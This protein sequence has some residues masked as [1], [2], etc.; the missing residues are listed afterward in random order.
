MLHSTV[1]PRASGLMAKGRPWLWAPVLVVGVVL[2]LLLLL[3]LED[4]QDVIYVPSVIL[5]GAAVVPIAFV[6]FISGRR[7]AFGVGGAA[8]AL[9]ALFGGV[10]GVLGAGTLEYETERS[11]GAL[12]LLSVGL[13]EEA[14]KL[15]IPA[16]V[17]LLLRDRRH[18]ADGLLLGVAAGAGFAVLET[19][20][21][22]FAVLVES[23]GDLTD[24]NSLLVDRGLLSPAAHMAW[25]GL[26]AAALWRAAGRRWRRWAP[27]RF[28]GV[29]LVVSSLHALWDGTSGGW[30]HAGLA[31]ISLGGLLWV[32]HR[33]AASGDRQSPPIAPA[34]PAAGRLAPGA[35]MPGTAGPSGV[36]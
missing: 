4:T 18:R 27:A 2:Y 10:I 19:M 15:I 12:P 25:T 6:T 20:G 17:L 36:S 8:T 1:G 13:I 23:R 33:L 5:V 22:A 24:V 34:W 9:T 16:A 35:P 30:A 29:Y 26:A 31:V 28:I 32:T 11:L 3:A 14:A 21:Y 7:L